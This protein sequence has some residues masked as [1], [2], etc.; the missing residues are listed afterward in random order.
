[1]LNNR[2]VENHRR[3]LTNKLSAKPELSKFEISKIK[4]SGRYLGKILGPLIKVVLPLT[5]IFMLLELTAAASAADGIFKR[6]HILFWDT[7]TS[8]QPDEK[9]KE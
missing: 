5:S 4:K 8:R 3:A 9:D 7:W 6:K 2:K 1:M